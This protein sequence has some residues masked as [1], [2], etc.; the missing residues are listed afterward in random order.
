MMAQFSRIMAVSCL[1]LSG[2]LAS[3]WDHPGQ[4]TTTASAFVDI[5]EARPD[6]VID[7]ADDIEAQRE[8]MGR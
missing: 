4:L 7:A 5:Q 3:A 2:T 1:S 8:Y 6:L